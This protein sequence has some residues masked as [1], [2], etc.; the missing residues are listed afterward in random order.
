MAEQ[1]LNTNDCS[2]ENINNILRFMTG[3]PRQPS[4]TV[5]PF[6]SMQFTPQ[7]LG[8]M[9]TIQGQVNPD[10]PTPVSQEPL[11]EQQPQFRK[12]ARPVL[13]SL[14]TD[15]TQISMIQNN[16]YMTA[17]PADIPDFS[18]SHQRRDSNV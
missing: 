1:L 5:S 12:I 13:P 18:S 15:F 8:K 10:S 4:A 7:D 6:G 11:P 2:S 17:S 16:Y 9:F 14:N 3:S